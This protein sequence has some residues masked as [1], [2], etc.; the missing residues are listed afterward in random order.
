MAAWFLKVDLTSLYLGGFE[1]ERRVPWRGCSL[2]HPQPQLYPYPSPPIVPQGTRTERLCEDP[3]NA[4]YARADFLVT[5]AEPSS[6][7]A[8][9]GTPS[10]GGGSSSGGGSGGSSRG[11]TGDSA[12]GGFRLGLVTR[13]FHGRRDSVF[14][15]L[16]CFEATLHG[17]GA[18]VVY[19]LDD[20][21][22]EDHSFGEEILAFFKRAGLENQ[23]SNHNT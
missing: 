7:S 16:P 15:T 3:F 19:V 21:S 1:P 14:L 10:P 9:K 23:V 6:A 2:T 22:E 17:S 20:E 11:G 8:G 4:E 12:A 13:T 18:E 5:P